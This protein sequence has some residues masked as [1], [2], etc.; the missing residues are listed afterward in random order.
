MYDAMA[1]YKNGQKMFIPKTNGFRGLGLCTQDKFILFSIEITKHYDSN[2]SKSKLTWIEWI[3][4]SVLQS[5]TFAHLYKVYIIIWHIFIVLI[6]TLFFFYRIMNFSLVMYT[7]F[8]EW[9]GIL[10]SIHWEGCWDEHTNMYLTHHSHRESILLSWDFQ[11][12]LDSF[13]YDCLH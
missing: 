2:T 3:T 5:F 10:I 7:R 1:W 4:K 9:T 13:Q 11:Y 6:F 8:D 12:I